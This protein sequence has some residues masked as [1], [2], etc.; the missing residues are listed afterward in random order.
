MSSLLMEGTGHVIHASERGAHCP[1][2][3]AASSADGRLT[4]WP[5]RCVSTPIPTPQAAALRVKRKGPQ[6]G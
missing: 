2:L 3:N 5:P 6:Q 4:E 1:A